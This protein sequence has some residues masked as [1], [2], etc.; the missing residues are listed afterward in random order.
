MLAAVAVAVAA[1]ALLET[2]AAVA[3]A[4]NTLLVET[5]RAPTIAESYAWF[6]ARHALKGH[7]NEREW[8]GVYYY[9]TFFWKLFQTDDFLRN[10]LRRLCTSKYFFL[11]LPIA[12]VCTTSPCLQL[13]QGVVYSNAFFRLWIQ[14]TN[15]QILFFI[16]HVV[17]FSY[18]FLT[19]T[20]INTT[21]IERQ[22][23]NAD[24][25]Y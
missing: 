20:T 10:A 1:S 17:Y 5:P 3:V 9:Y 2:R 11:F 7:V 24:A 18:R 6:F 13:L 12:A 25:T 8:V 19:Y 23:F 4:A 14:Q 16:R 15:T 22:H 21:V